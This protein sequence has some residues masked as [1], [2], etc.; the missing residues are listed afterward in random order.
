MDNK[1][2]KRKKIIEV[3]TKLFVE[4]GFHGTPTSLIAKEAGIATGTL[5]N[6]FKTKD[7]LINEIFKDIKSEQK[8]IILKDLDEAKTSKLKLKKIWKNLIVW[9][10]NNPQERKFINYFSNSNFISDDTKT[11]IKKNY[12][13]L[14]DIFREI[15]EKKGMKNTNELML[16]LNFMGAC[17]FTGKYF[18]ITKEPYNEK[19]CDEPFERFCKSIE[20]CDED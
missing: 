4:R 12:K 7:I 16:I 14:L 20:L 5:F 10:I 2:K 3:A 6:Y 9:G 11:E 15:I 1:I 18:H 17:I 13:F 8:E 19:V